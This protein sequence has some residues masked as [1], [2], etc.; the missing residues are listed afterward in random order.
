MYTPF[1]WLTMN[2]IPIY[3]KSQIVKPEDNESQIVEPEDNELQI[4]EPDY[5]LSKLYYFFYILLI[6]IEV[7]VDIFNLST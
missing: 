3:N 2:S 7:L 1:S 6:L 5:K 4:V